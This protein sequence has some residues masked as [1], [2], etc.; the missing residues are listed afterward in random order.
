MAWDMMSFQ[1]IGD[2]L[3]YNARQGGVV[4]VRLQLPKHHISI[5][6]AT[7]TE[8]GTLLSSILSL[9]PHVLRRTMRLPITLSFCTVGLFFSTVQ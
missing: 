6:S 1:G 7:H 5:P 8:P 9:T 4:I 2:F 3:C